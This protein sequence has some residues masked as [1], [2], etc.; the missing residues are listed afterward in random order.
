[1]DDKNVKDDRI[2]RD[3]QDSNL[4]TADLAR[5]AEEGKRNEGRQTGDAARAGTTRDTGAGRWPLTAAAAATAAS[6]AREGE[7]A[8]LFSEGDAKDFRA[9]W[10][11]LQVGFVDE[12]RRAVEQADSLVAEAIKRLAGVFADERQKLERQ[13][14]RGDNVSTE[15]LRVALQRY[16]AFF[17]RLLSV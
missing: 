13:W 4:T 14:D 9:R 8:R 5:S 10:E 17:G 16:R 6:P 12:P 15:D 7:Y 3:Q 1:M 11:N 2:K